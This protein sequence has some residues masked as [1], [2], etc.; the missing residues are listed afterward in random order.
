MHEWILLQTTIDSCGMHAQMYQGGRKLVTK[1]LKLLP[2][3]FCA[4]CSYS[5]IFYN[6]ITIFGDHGSI[7]PTFYTK[8][9][10]ANIPKA[11][12]TGK[13]SVFL[14]LLGSAHIIKFWWKQPQI[15]PITYSYSVQPLWF[16]EAKSRRYIKISISSNKLFKWRLQL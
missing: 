5:F 13:P 2:S 10:H 3:N 7:S 9:L 16:S 6:F 15:D 14:V 11:Q 4:L 12:N 1:M 8:F